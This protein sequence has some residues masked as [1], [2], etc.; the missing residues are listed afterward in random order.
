MLKP[1]F[2]VPGPAPR[3]RQRPGAVR[4][5]QRRRHEAPP[6]QHPGRVREGGQEVRQAGDDLRH[7]AG[8]HDAQGR[9]HAARLPRRS[10]FPGPQGP[11][12]CGVGTGRVIGRE[13]IEEHTQACIDAGLVIEGTN[14]EVMPGQWEF[15]IGAA[16]AARRVSDHLYVARWLLH[17]IA[18]DFDVDHHASPPSRRRATGTAPARTPTSPPRRCARATTPIETP[19]ARRSA[20]KWELHVN[21]LRRRHRGAA[22]PAST[23]RRRGTSSATACPTAA[24]SVRIPWQVAKDGKGYAE[25]RRPNANMDPYDGHPP[26][27]RDDRS[28]PREQ[29]HRDRATGVPRGDPVGCLA[30]LPDSADRLERE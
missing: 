16:D 18:E 22:S 11:Y 20:S 19:P 1:V 27:H 17:R 28:A 26:D 10:G 15:Q 3:R 21:E 13:I 9:R 23:R 30:Q 12:Y 2:V 4:G 7:R 14:A 5:A 29:R 8:V 25:D 24:P 6:D